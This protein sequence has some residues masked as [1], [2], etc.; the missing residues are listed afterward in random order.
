VSYSARG[1]V[2]GCWAGEGGE[3]ELSRDEIDDGDH[4]G[5]VAV[6]PGAGLGGLDQRVDLSSRP[7]LR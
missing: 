1:H 6:A 5:F 3:L 4:L 2:C 7:L